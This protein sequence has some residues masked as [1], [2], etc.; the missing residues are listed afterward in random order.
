MVGTGR[1]KQQGPLPV[2]D[3][4]SITQDAVVEE[5]VKRDLMNRVAMLHMVECSGGKLP[6]LIEVGKGS[7]AP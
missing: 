4:V 5:C 2:E 6:F 1:L 7:I 3:T